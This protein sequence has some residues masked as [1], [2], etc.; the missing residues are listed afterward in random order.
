MVSSV[1]GNPAPVILLVSVGT[2]VAGFNVPEHQV[3][4]VIT[5]WLFVTVTEFILS[6]FKKHTDGVAELV[7]SLKEAVTHC[8]G[9]DDAPGKLITEVRECLT[10]HGIRHPVPIARSYEHVVQSLFSIKNP[11]MQ[12]RIIRFAS[13]ALDGIRRKNGFPLSETNFPS[14]QDLAITFAKA[15]GESLHMTCIYTPLYYFWQF[16]NVSSSDDPVHLVAFNGMPTAQEE[17]LGQIERVRAMY[18]GDRVVRHLGEYPLMS[19]IAMVWFFFFCANF[20]DVSWNRKDLPDDSIIADELYMWRYE[21]TSR[22]LYLKG[23]W[24]ID[25]TEEGPEKRVPGWERWFRKDRHG[26]TCGGEGVGL[27]QHHVGKGGTV[28]HPKWIRFCEKLKSYLTEVG[29][30]ELKG[31]DVQDGFSAY[32]EMCLWLLGRISTAES[33]SAEWPL[34][35]WIRSYYLQLNPERRIQL[36]S[37]FVDFERRDSTG[38]AFLGHLRHI[39]STKEALARI[40]TELTYKSFFS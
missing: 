1:V 33:E 29:K 32:K 22:T 4:T 37:Y 2:L 23:S 12:S 30:L 14:Y 39:D 3:A 17:E 34:Q 40:R 28:D 27:L 20:R 8:L 19:A 21:Q 31:A 38:R 36:E 6:Q 11:E 18:V 24:S 9:T 13:D 25:P 15:A 16:A 26:N 7:T 10:Q 35:R 5:L